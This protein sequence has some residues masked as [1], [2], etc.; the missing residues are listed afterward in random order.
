M[1]TPGPQVF[2]TL[3]HGR[4]RWEKEKTQATCLGVGT[5]WI[6]NRSSKSIQNLWKDAVYQN[7]LILNTDPVSRTTS[8][9]F[10]LK[11]VV[12]FTLLMHQSDPKCGVLKFFHGCGKAKSLSPL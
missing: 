12:I 2:K 1:H 8:Q 3:F 11:R 5:A 4:H 9:C 6:G 10:T 7:M